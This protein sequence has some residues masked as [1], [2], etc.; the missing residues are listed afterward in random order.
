MEIKI[1]KDEKDNLVVE[2][3]N[4]TVAE[5]LRVYLNKDDSVEMAAWK[6]EH[7]DKPV[8][9][10]IKTNGK[11]AKKALEAAVVAI[12]KDTS[13]ILDEFKKSAK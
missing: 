2:T 11:T 3:N 7:P 5:L 4:Q 12:E 10:E 1:L 6:R 13:K 9:F 8:V